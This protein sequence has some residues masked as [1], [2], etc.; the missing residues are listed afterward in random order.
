VAF[1]VSRKKGTTARLAI[2][3]W[4]QG[5]GLQVVPLGI[6]YSSFRFL[7]KCDLKL[8]R[9]AIT[10]VLMKPF[11]K[12]INAFNDKLEEQLKKISLFEIDPGDTATIKKY[13]LSL[14]LYKKILFIFPALIGCTLHPSTSSGSLHLH[15]KKSTVDH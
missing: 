9:E 2:T 1:K 4:Q 6:N 15:K 12:A 8:W 14:N 10:K 11:C 3:A 7:V 5:I 13:F